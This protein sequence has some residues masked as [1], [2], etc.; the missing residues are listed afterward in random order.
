MNENIFLL[1]F[2][3][4]RNYLI[5]IFILVLV[6]IGLYIFYTTYLEPGLTGLQAEWSEKRLLAASGNLVDTTSVYRRGTADLSAFYGRVP[7][8]KEF[9]A[10]IGDLFE[11]ANNNSL[12]VGTI[13]YKP[14]IIK[15]EKLLA[16]S[17]GFNVAGKYAAIKSFISDIERLRQ[18]AV[19]D[20]ISLNGKADEEYVEMKVQMTAYFKGEGQ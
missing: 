5:V 8:K 2:N 6:N 15:G 14:E 11:T 10:F 19:I 18:I 17:I 12:K 1:I 4:R 13:S 9:A 3:A 16:Y 7:R 20:N